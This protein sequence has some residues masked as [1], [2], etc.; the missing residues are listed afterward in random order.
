MPRKFRN[1]LKK[2]KDSNHRAALHNQQKA[3]HEQL[4]NLL[5]V[6]EETQQIVEET[7]EAVSR[8]RETHTTSRPSNQTDRQ[9]NSPQPSSSRRV[10]IIEDDLRTVINQRTRPLRPDDLRKS[11]DDRKQ[12]G[13]KRKRE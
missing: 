1:I 4:E 13:E 7:Q 3:H 10:Q 12:T 6:V 8:H 5:Q 9:P 11:L 2:K